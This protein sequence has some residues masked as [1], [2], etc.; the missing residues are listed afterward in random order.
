MRIFDK[1]VGFIAL[2]YKLYTLAYLI[3][4]R[5]FGLNIFET[6]DVIEIDDD[7]VVRTV[8]S[9]SGTTVTFAPALA[10]ASTAGML[11]E[12]WGVGATDLDEDFHV[13]SGSPCIDA[14]DN[15]AVPVG[16]STDVDDGPRFYDDPYTTD[17]GNGTAPIVDMGIDEYGAGDGDSD[18][19]DDAWEIQY[20][21]D[22]ETSDGSGDGDVDGLTD[23]EE[24]QYNT[25][26]DD[27][28][29][30]DDTWNDGDEVAAGTDPLD[31][32]DYPG[33]SIPTLSEWGMIVLSLLLLSAG[34]VMIKRRQ[35]L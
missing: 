1:K 5:M 8:S 3:P 25:Y 21:T 2:D 27:E 9:A 12:N 31:E 18:L 34:M 6:D 16:V 35:E 22:I 33:A 10:P 29:S 14:G 4:C 26:P 20:F 15:T 32:N 11:V 24:Y 17:T 19:M 30:D 13:H 28:D 23:L 7:G